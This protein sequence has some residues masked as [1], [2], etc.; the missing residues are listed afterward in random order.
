M[1]DR[2]KLG[3]RISDL[4]RQS[5]KKQGEIAHD[6]GADESSVSQWVNGKWTPKLECLYKIARYF[7]TTLDALLGGVRGMIELKPCPFCGGKAQYNFDMQLEPI[8][9]FC[10]ACHVVVRF[11]RIKPMGKRTAGSVMDEIAEA[12]NRRTE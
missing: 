1:I 9:V 4:I 3:Y 8:G 12:W 7:G 6:L 10:P 2:K 11:A 5:G